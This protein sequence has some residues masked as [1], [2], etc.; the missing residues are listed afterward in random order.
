M[1]TAVYLL[2]EIPLRC[3]V[4][5]IIADNHGGAIYSDGNS[6]ISFEENSKTMFSSNTAHL[7][8]AIE[9]YNNRYISFEGNSKTVFSNNTADYGGA[10]CSYNHSYISFE[11]NSTISFSNNSADLGGAIHSLDHCYT[12]FREDST[13]VFSNNIAAGH[14]AAVYAI[15]HSDI[16]FDDNSKIT[17]TNNKA[18]DGTTVYSKTNSKVMTKGDSSVV[19]N[20]VSA[21]WCNNT[22]LHHYSS[23]SNVITID[24]NGIVRCSYQEGF[25]CQK[26]ICQCDEFNRDFENNSVINITNAVILSSNVSFNKLTNI[27]LIGD[28]NPSVYCIN[29][30]GLTW[31]YSKNIV[32]KGITWIGCGSNTVSS[33]VSNIHSE[34]HNSEQTSV[35]MNPVIHLQ[36]SLN[37]LIQ[38]CSFLYSEGPAVVL[39]KV[40]G[41]TN[42]THCKF[43]NSSSYS[44]H[45]AAIH[46][47]SNDTANSLFTISD[48][49]F[50]YNNAKSLVY[51]ENRIMQTQKITICNSKF[52]HNQVVSIHVINH[53]LTLSGNIV[54][55]SNN[56]TGICVTDSSVVTFGENS[57]VSFIQNAAN[58]RG[59]AILSRDHSAI[60]FD[61]NSKATFHDN[62][63]TS[64]TIY[65]E[66]SSNV[67]FRATSIVT[68]SSNSASQ[69]G[70]AI[71]SFDNSQVKF[72]GNAEII[73]NNNVVHFNDNNKQLGGTVFSENNSHVSFEGNSA[74]MFSNNTANF[75][76]AI[77]LSYNSNVNFKNESKV[78]FNK[79]IANNGGAVALHDNCTA[80]IEQLSNLTF[81]DNFASQCGG[82]LHFSHNSNVSFTD[83]S[84]TLFANNS[85]E[86]YGGAVCFNASSSIKFDKNSISNFINNTASFAG[87]IYSMDNSVTILTKNSNLMINNNL[88]R[89][90]YGRQF[91]NES[92][93][94]IIGT[95]GIVRCSDHKEY[96]ICQYNNCFCK[97]LEDIPSNSE[98]I[99]T[100]VIKLNV[101]LEELSNISV[102]GYNNSSIHCENEGGLQFISCSN[103]SI[104]NI[105][106]RKTINDE[107]DTSKIIP[108]IKFYNSSNIII[109]YCT[110]QQSVGQA[111][112]LSEVSE[113][114][115]IKHCNFVNF[116]HPLR[117][118]GAAIHYSMTCTECSQVQLIISDCYFTN[119]SG[120]ASLIY[121][122]QHNS[123]NQCESIILQNSKFDSNQGICVYLSNQNLEII[124]NVAF[125][126]NE[127]DNGAGIFISN[128]SDVTFGKGSNV[129]F[130]HN[131]ATINGG[132]IYVNNW[133]SVVFEN[134]AHVMFTSNKATRSGGTI[135]SYN[136]SG[137]LLKENS[138][139]SFTNSNAELG[140][141]LY[142]ENNS[143]ISTRNQP[144]LTI[145][146]S[147]AVC[148][149]AIYLKQN[150]NMTITDNTTFEFL[151]TEAREDGGC[152]YSDSKSS[153][154]FSGNFI[155]K[156]YNS[157][158]RTGGVIYSC[159]DS[160]IV[161][162]NNSQVW[163]NHST[164]VLGGT[165][166]IDKNSFIMT[167]GNSTLT[168]SNSKAINGGAS[169]LTQNSN[170]TATENSTI[171]FFNNEA[172]VGGGSIYS[173][174]TSSITFKGNA[175]INITNN[176]ATY[177]GAIYSTGG[178]NIEFV[179]SSK[180]IFDR[181]TAKQNGGCIYIKQSS[182]QFKETSSIT[183]EH[184]VVFNGAGG[185]I[186]CTEN[187]NITFISCK[188]KFYR[189]TVYNGNGGAICCANSVAVFK[190]TSDVEFDSNQ[191]TDGGAADFNMN[192][193]L[194]ITDNV[195]VTFSQNSATMGGAVNCRVNS[196]CTFEM[197]STLALISNSAIQNGGAFHL[198]NNSCIEFKQFAN[199]HFDRNKA[200]LGG[201]IYCSEMSFIISS[202]SSKISYNDNSLITFKNNTASHDGGAIYIGDRSHLTFMGDRNVTFSHNNASDY[203][204]AIYVEIVESTVNFTNSSNISFLYNSA[205]TGS[206]VYINVPAQCNSTCL[207]NSVLG[208]N[209]TDDDIITSPS[210]IELYASN[211]HCVNC[212]SDSYYIKNIMLGQKI[213]LDACMYDYYDHPVDVARFILS[214]NES[215]GY[216]LDSNNILITCNR[217]LELVSI[218]GNA[219]SAMFNFPINISL[220][221]NHRFESK[222]VLTRLMVE[223]SPCHL[224]FLYNEKSQ[225][226]ECYNASDIVFCSGSSSTIKRGYWF[227]RV[228][229]MSLCPINYCDFT[230]CNKAS[231][232]CDLS[233]QRIDQC[234]SHRSGTA[235]GNCENGYT[236]PFY[237]TECINE[238]NC[239]VL[240]TII[241]VVLTVV[242]WIALVI[243]V[244]ITMYYKV[245]I[246]YLY[247]ITYY[248]SMVDV[249]LSEYLYIPN[250]LY[251]TINIM[252]SIVKLTPQFLGKLCLV[253]GLSGI[254]QTFI[255]YVHPLAVSLI[256]VMIVM[257]ARISRR[258][259]V[260]ISRGIIRVICF[261][262]LLLYTSVTVTSLHL[263]KYL[264]FSNVDKI[265]TYLSPDIEYFQGRHLVYA[266]IALLCIIFIV[267][268]VP[269]ILMAEPFLNHKINFV[270]MKPILDQFQGC[271]KDK[272]RWFAGC[273]MICRIVI[274]TITIIFSSSDFTSRYLLITTCAAILLIHLS[275]RPYKS[276]LLNAFDGLLL[277][278]LVLVSILLLVE[279]INSDSV[280]PITFALL[281]LPLTV[282]AVLCASIHKDV[283]K[284]IV[285]LKFVVYK[286][287][288]DRNNVDDSNSLKT[289]TSIGTGDYDLIIDD[290]M[291]MNATIC[292]V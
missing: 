181:N 15:T 260:F 92:K 159:N 45:G 161:F 188:V 249:L 184:S 1:T 13:T 39:S 195:N 227:G 47:T 26:Q 189:N 46:Y 214:I 256:L 203:G 49:S 48:C 244:F 237:A 6:C 152:I 174:Y 207:T 211:V 125:E 21:K 101:S 151:N 255:H 155:T 29:G 138:I 148:G 134:D 229:G 288:V 238:H 209:T 187:S 164:A 213:L 133:S 54:F 194:T 23:E 137:I 250:G 180:T 275:V 284:K 56:G 173:N 79:N 140:G 200:I 114:V 217:T 127:A 113:D 70:A 154:M 51:L 40:S 274:I 130:V 36:F 205:R 20:D 38:N 251:I 126:N 183:F 223:L 118:H 196:Y 182:I 153:I 210:K 268:G 281:I 231:E 94:I 172:E 193:T 185:A 216:R 83:N 272:Y 292:D 100:D 179:N 108:Q 122:E 178:S 105:T 24:S 98:V 191:A 107:R 19:F 71:H 5:I 291:R 277:L 102:I 120:I 124:G 258:L 84:F 116:K 82:A 279:F 93:D 177:G 121:F 235:C 241:V 34:M 31:M 221:D 65:S 91:T 106:W 141:T 14:G 128:H 27:S 165:L 278:L 63:A 232:F 199:A 247:A 112:V 206:S 225:K 57:T 62:K 245:S 3:L 8:G 136:N 74:A 253:R 176:E 78:T 197:Y 85:A 220:Y 252:Y 267:I 59:G 119:N 230:S 282:F 198:E 72:T 144:E 285:H 283:I 204:G 135:Y 259:S 30:S 158:A 64:G 287:N 69:Y 168:V 143:S 228:N 58:G 254:D 111:V 208:I 236:L 273:Y 271:Y 50:A 17:L 156:L 33:R 202:S 290:S 90:N 55:R 22:C 169:Y 289:L 190:G 4:I 41:E 76:A 95:N 242:Y 219:T 139:A 265:Y 9:S 10:I 233:P 170:M 175:M 264:K 243:A 42:I 53:N 201:A 224:G 171:A 123:N 270:K 248:Y 286:N 81:N 2:K 12:S 75:G 35:L 103:V 162:K 142:A 89:W 129:T 145:N 246:G 261:L 263:V 239:T 73:F 269:L 157:R 44:D 257:L 32:L 146:G 109:D 80:T 97:S 147:T 25:I 218:Y 222:N 215:Q 160:S 166:Y 11:G 280:V 7:G 262:L 88:A 212:T 192:S 96:Y 77:L 28:N 226:C 60:L 276:K 131:T 87:N 68:F 43:V 18:T 234:R 37:I 163:F 66:N 167:K 110:F 186:F 61:Q 16:T 117:E 99:I 86:G 115:N 132:A 149:G 104:T 150:S 67:I 52:Y 266:I 240:Q